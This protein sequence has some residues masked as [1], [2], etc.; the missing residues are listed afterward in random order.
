MAVGGGGGE[1]VK[2]GLDGKSASSALD[3]GAAFAT[4]QQRGADEIHLG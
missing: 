2:L 1:P 4:G 3:V